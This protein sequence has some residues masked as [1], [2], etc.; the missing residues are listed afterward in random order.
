[1]GE[2]MTNGGAP[3]LPHNPFAKAQA[4]HI[5]AGAVAI[6]SER[7]IAE[8]QGRLLIAKRFPRDEAGAFARAMDACRRPSLAEVANYRFPRGGQQVEGPS[9]RLAE[10]LAR[11]WSNIAYGIRELSRKEGESEMEAFAWDMQTNV[12][13]TQTF[14]ARHLR[15]KRGGPEALRDERDIYEL[16]ANLA[17]RR[18]RARILAVLPPDLVD[19]A[20]AQCRETMKNGSDKPLSDRI[21]E[22]TQAFTKLGVT[23]EMLSARLGRPLDSATPDDLVDLRGIYQGIRDGASSVR[24][25]FA[26]KEA[27]QG[28]RLDQLE[29]QAAPAQQPAAEPKIDNATP[30]Q[31]AGLADDGWP[32]PKSEASAKH[33]KKGA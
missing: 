14:T 1:M 7:A 6:E 29:Q 18:L 5:S 25:W 2:V 27:P 17:A 26:P 24:D 4:Q 8:A 32:G 13:S 3:P 20:V 19:A 22:M 30:E 10:E 16:T 33:P 15:D 31:L 28:S 9:I 23:A 21:R 11:C 12:L